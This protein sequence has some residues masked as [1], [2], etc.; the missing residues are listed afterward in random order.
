[1]TYEEAKNHLEDYIKANDGT[2]P[3][4]YDSALAVALDAV[5]DCLDMGLTHDYVGDRS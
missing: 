3:E 4:P 1:M 5:C 2:M